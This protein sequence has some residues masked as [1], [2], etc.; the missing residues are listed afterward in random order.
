MLFPF[1]SRE[2][3]TNAAAKRCRIWFLALT[4]GLAVGA[5]ILG[6]IGLVGTHQDSIQGAVILAVAVVSA[7]LNGAFDALVCIVIHR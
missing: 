2:N 3:T 7:G 4:E 1:P 5:L 6:G